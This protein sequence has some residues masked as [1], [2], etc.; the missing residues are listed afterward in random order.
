MSLPRVLVVEDDAGIADMYRRLLGRVAE[1]VVAEEPSRALELAR[2]GGFDAV[3]SDVRMTGI[4]GFGFLK[5]LR[6]HAPALA[7]RFAFV[8][9]DERAVALAARE[10]V[11]ILRKP[12]EMS[13]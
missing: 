13:D 2:A 7:H 4:G 1:V 5:L 12:F 6:H 8:T 9:A 10:G 3:L 11:P